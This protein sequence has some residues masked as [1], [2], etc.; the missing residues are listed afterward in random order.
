MRSGPHPVS[1][2]VFA[3]V[4]CV[5]VG[6]PGCRGEP[7]PGDPSLRLELAIAPTPPGVGA[8]RIIILL[9]DTAGTPIPGASIRV[10]GN[11]SHAGM[12][13][14]VDTAE[15]VAPGRYAVPEFHFNM[16][17]EWVLSARATLPDGRWT[18][19]RLPTSV[20]AAPPGIRPD[21]GEGAPQHPGSSEG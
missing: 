21:T 6:L 13:P 8:A 9:S 12:V 19:A 7:V 5:L 17:G 1:H 16:A 20:L 10:E 11:M 18:V 4:A 2:P 15:A 14:V 3:L